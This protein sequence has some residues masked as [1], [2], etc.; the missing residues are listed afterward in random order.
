MRSVELQPDYAASMMTTEKIK[1]I[2]AEIFQLD[3]SSIRLDMSPDDVDTWDSLN[4]LRLI[5]EVESSFSIQ[6]SMQQ[7][8]KIHSLADLVEAVAMVAG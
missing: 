7:I 5:T 6:L 8:Q 4:H 2:A 3:V 1:Q